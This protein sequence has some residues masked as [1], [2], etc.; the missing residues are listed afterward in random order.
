MPTQ[1]ELFSQTKDKIKTREPELVI[2]RC[3]EHVTTMCESNSRITNTIWL[4]VLVVRVG[5]TEKFGT[6]Y[7]GYA[8]YEVVNLTVQG[9]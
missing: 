2:N 6:S 1:W 8:Q 4:Y 9:K 5:T 7:V 3:V